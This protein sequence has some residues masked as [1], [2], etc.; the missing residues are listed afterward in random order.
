MALVP[1]NFPPGVYNSGTDYQSKGRWVRSSLVRWTNG[2]MQP[3]KGWLTRVSVGS[4][5]VRGALA[6]VDNSGDR[7]VAAG[8]FDNLSVFNS[9]NSVSDITPVG[10]TT[11]TVDAEIN[12]GYGGGLYGTGAYGIAR[13]DTG[14]IGAATVWALDNFGEN[15]IALS[16]ADG[17]IYQWALNTGTPAAAVTNAPTGCKWALVSDERFLFAFGP[18]GN[19]RTVQWSDREAITTW[20]PSATN[21]AGDYILQT[22]GSLVTAARV[23]GQILILTDRDAHTA[24]YQGPPFV[25]G[26]ERVGSRCGAISPLC[27]VS[28][29]AGAYWMGQNGFHFYSGGAVQD[30]PCEVADYVFSDMNADQRS[31]V[32]AVSNAAFSE[33]WWFYPSR[34]AKE[35]DRY[36]SYNYK[37][38]HWAIGEIERTAGVDA[39]VFST[40]VWFSPDGTAYNHEIGSAWGGAD[41]FAESGPLEIGNGDNVMSVLSLITDEDTT[42]GTVSAILKAKYYPN[43]TETEFGP[44]VMENT[45]DVRVTGRQV[46]MRIVGGETSDWR[47]GVIRADVRGRGLR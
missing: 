30:L 12:L 25:Y 24:T 23:R 35:I 34:A 29:D 31:K 17:K 22:Q 14:T 27:V 15:L 8:T 33:I 36:V 7:W 21:E 32:F 6:W 4:D 13:P 45:T 18:G 19:R 1:L 47:V 38:N 9:G 26:F 44:Y 41:V 39:G 3:V 10:L 37:E 16:T 40:P 11:G 2:T 43:D 46:S 42:A 20:T 28:A 5:P